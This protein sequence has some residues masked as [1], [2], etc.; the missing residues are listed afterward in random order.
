MMT[1]FKKINFFK[2]STE[3]IF[4]SKKLISMRERVIECLGFSFV[5]NNFSVT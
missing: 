2:L 3:D 1:L 4:T 5:L